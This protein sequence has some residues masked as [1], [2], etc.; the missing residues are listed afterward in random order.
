MKKYIYLVALL[1]V[2]SYVNILGNNFAIDDTL[3][4]K[5][6]QGIRSINIVDNFKGVVPPGHEG[7]YRPIRQFLYSVYYQFW[8]EAPLGYHLHA[9][10]V[11]AVSTILIYLII[12]KILDTRAALFG[13][14]LFAL[15]PV[16]TESIA[17]TASGMDTTGIAFALASFYFYL[18]KKMKYSYILAGIAFFS[19]EIALTLP[20]LIVWYEFCFSKPKFHAPYWV[21]LVFYAVVRFGILGISGVRAEVAGGSFYPALL[22]M[23]KAMAKYIELLF[24]PIKLANEQ[25]LY[26]NIESFIYRGYNKDLIIDQKFLDPK[27]LLPFLLLIAV[28]LVG[29]YLRKKHREVTFG[30]GFHFIALLPVMQFIPQGAV[31]NEKNLYLASFGFVF[32][33]A[34]LLDKFYPRFKAVVILFLVII[35]SLYFVRTFTRNFDW[36]DDLTLWSREV[37]TYPYSAYGYY[38]LGNAYRVQKRPNEA[39]VALQRAYAINPRFAVAVATIG[40]VYD[41]R[42]EKELAINFY[43]KA[44]EVDPTFYEVSARIKEL[45]GENFKLK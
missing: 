26:G 39:L 36:K 14:V 4:I 11:H 27:I 38:S 7:A 41:E 44:L 35:S 40:L 24:L 3:F 10:V 23:I 6:W 17:Y 30:I 22:T 20:F 33:F 29:Y 21:M 16:H 12:A 25:L 31:L 2:L 32:V 13:S 45:S 37:V 34:Y 1:A 19:H 5:G 42:G 18:E 8:G 15:H 28:L 43:K 9:I